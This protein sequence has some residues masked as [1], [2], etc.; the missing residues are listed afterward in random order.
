[1]RTW[2]PRDR[3]RAPRARAVARAPA[4][5]HGRPAHRRRPL[6]NKDPLHREYATPTHQAGTT[7]SHATL[8]RFRSFSRSV[9]FSLLVTP[10][11]LSDVAW[12]RRRRL[13]CRHNRGTIFGA[14]F[15]R[16]TTSPTE[17]R[18]SDDARISRPDDYLL[19]GTTRSRSDGGRRWRFF[20]TTRSESKRN[21][22]YVA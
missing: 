17:F 1:M 20:Q 11:R 8:S 16:S 9:T 22:T 15:R 12:H 5:R 19:H 21:R 4:A 7:P 14:R 10:Q 2:R 18:A 3:R 6:A 13:L